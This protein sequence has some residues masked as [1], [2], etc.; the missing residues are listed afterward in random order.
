MRQIARWYDVSIEYRGNMDNI[1]L[2]GVFSRKSE[3]G[4]MLDILEATGA[5]HYQLEGNK[6]IVSTK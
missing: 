1:Y 3:V 2:S 4:Q 5:V 6:I